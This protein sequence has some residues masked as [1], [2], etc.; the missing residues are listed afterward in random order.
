MSSL[1]GTVRVQFYR[2]SRLLSASYL[3]DVVLF[4]I[5]EKRVLHDRVQDLPCGSIGSTGKR[6]SS[7]YM[8]MASRNSSDIGRVLITSF[9]IVDSS[10]GILGNLGREH[11]MVNLE[12]ERRG[13]FISMSKKMEQREKGTLREHKRMYLEDGRRSLSMSMSKKTVNR[14]KKN[15]PTMEECHRGSVRARFCRS[16]IWS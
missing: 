14:E 12:E 10:T 7:S 16:C 9:W 11:K 3:L 4:V 6:Q 5:L 2:N 13:T 1:S 15:S 8:H